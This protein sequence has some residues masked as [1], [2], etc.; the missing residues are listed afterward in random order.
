MGLF[1]LSIALLSGSVASADECSGEPANRLIRLTQIIG[2]LIVTNHLLGGQNIVATAESCVFDPQTRRFT[3]DLHV[4]WDGRFAW[5]NHYEI[6]AEVRSNWEADAVK[7]VIVSGND[8]V[9][10]LEFWGNI[11]NVSLDA[12]N[13]GR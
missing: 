12:L 13:K 9:R 7:F 2:P 5:W 3:F 8:A 10:N 6:L 11:L 4:L 1:A